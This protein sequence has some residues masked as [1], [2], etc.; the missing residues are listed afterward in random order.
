[1]TPKRCSERCTA[2]GAVRSAEDWQETVQKAAEDLDT[3][4]FLIDRL[5]AAHFLDP[6]LMAALLIL[7]RRLIDE[8]GATTAAELMLID[9]AVLSYYHQ[10][11]ITGWIGDLAPL[12][13]SEF[14][15]YDTTLRAKMKRYYGD[16][17]VRGLAVEDLVR[18]IG[19]QLMPLLDRSNRMLLRN[20]KA[21]Q[22]RR[23]GPTPSVS[24]GAAGQVNVATSQA[25]AVNATGASDPTRVEAAVV[26]LDPRERARR[27][28]PRPF[29]PSPMDDQ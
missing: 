8:H 19:E 23:D 5:G 7:R 21:L 14:F 1:M 24:I 12:V 26:A 2:G 25:N 11:R 29:P 6:E 17:K 4:G 28:D 16:D 20:L 9:C 13:E 27:N 10:I 3:G 18:R 15:G 22:A